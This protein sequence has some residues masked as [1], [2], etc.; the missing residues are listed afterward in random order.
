MGGWSYSVMVITIGF[1]PVEP[2]SIPGMTFSL[3][4]A[5]EAHQPS[6]LGVVGSSPT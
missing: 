3:S 6:K 2:G 4:G 5:M 1:D